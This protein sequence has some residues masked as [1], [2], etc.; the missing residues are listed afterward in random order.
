MGLR[1][2]HHILLQF[3]APIYR[4]IFHRGMSVAEMLALEELFTKHHPSDEIYTEGFDLIHE[5]LVASL[6][7]RFKRDDLQLADC[8]TLQRG[9]QDVLRDGLSKY[10]LWRDSN[11]VYEPEMMQLPNLWHTMLWRCAVARA[12]ADKKPSEAA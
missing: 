7:K 1:L 10:T 4:T 12:L 8:P 3:E 2:S 11:Y 9:V 5:V 6:A